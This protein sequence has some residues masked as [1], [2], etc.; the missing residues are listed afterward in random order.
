[1]V[2]EIEKTN[3]PV[4]FITNMT[5]VAQVI[6]ANRIIPG[7][8]IKNPCCNPELPEEDQSRMKREYIDRALKALSTDVT[9]QMFF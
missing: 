6:G 7:I 1:M 9:D 4:A 8:A 2:K 5:P 3:I